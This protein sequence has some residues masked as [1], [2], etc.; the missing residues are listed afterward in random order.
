VPIRHGSLSAYNH[1]KCR[2]KACR[3]ANAAYMRQY[4]ARNAP[5][6]EPEA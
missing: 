6:V 2:C 3:G 4:R 5:H 1:R